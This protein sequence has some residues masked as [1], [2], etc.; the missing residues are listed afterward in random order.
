MTILEDL[1]LGDQAYVYTAYDT[2]CEF[3]T[4]QKI[5]ITIIASTAHYICI[6]YNKNYLNGRFNTTDRYGNKIENIF[7]YTQKM[8][9]R[10]IKVIPNF[11]IINIF[12]GFP[13]TIIAKKFNIIPIQ[14]VLFAIFH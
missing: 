8:G 10:D 12:I 5:L 14:N 7:N 1:K 2:I 3:E 6:G 4:N 13:Q 9:W 11:L